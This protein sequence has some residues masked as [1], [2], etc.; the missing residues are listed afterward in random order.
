EIAES[1]SSSGIPILLSGDRGRENLRLVICYQDGIFDPDA[2]K[3]EALLRALPIDA[4]SITAAALRII[5]NSRDEIQSRLDSCHVSRRQRQV[6]T[7]VFQCRSFIL[8]SS[9]ITAARVANAQTNQ[10][11]QPMRK[12]QRMR[13][14]L[15][16][17]F[18]VTLH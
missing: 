13:A 3:S 18:C 8:R 7:Q 1:I 11:T 6:H 2:A 12:E 14:L 5:E 17:R 16:Q 15:D 10:M 9:R 4:A